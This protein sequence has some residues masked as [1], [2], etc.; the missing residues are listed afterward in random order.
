[1]HAPKGSVWTALSWTVELL[2]EEFYFDLFD[3][4]KDKDS[5]FSHT[6]EDMKIDSTHV[7]AN[8]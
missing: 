1:M 4:L 6:D 3:V 8:K 5:Q 2:I 7:G